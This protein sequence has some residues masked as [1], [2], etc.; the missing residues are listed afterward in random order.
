[1]L[2]AFSA[3]K[4][5]GLEHVQPPQLGQTVPD[6][7]ALE[8]SG[9]I[10][11]TPD[12]TAMLNGQ[13]GGGVAM[14]MRIIIATSRSLGA[15]RLIEIES[16]HVD[17][18]LYHGQASLDFAHKLAAQGARVRVP[19]TLNVGSVD[20]LHPATVLRRSAEEV[21]VYEGGRALMDG[22]VALGC[23][24]TWTCAPYQL[25]DR[26]AFGSHIAWAESNAVVFANSVIGA[27]TERYGDFIDICSAV[28]GLAPYAGLHTDEGRTACVVFDCTPLSS[29]TLENELT[30]PLLGYLVGSRTGIGNPVILGLPADTP[31]EHLKALGAA[32][33]SAGGVALFHAVGVTPE[34]PTLEA[35][36]DRSG[37]SAVHAI[38]LAE[39]EQARAELTTCASGPLDA[40][41]V[42]TP[43]ASI[44]EIRTLARLV[45]PA[46]RFHDR[47]EVFLSTGRLT[48]AEA[49][50]EGLVEILEMS[51]VRIVVDTCTYVTS[52]LSANVRNVMTNSAKWAH[53]AP[54]KLGVDVAIGTIEECIESA[55]R[56]EVTLHP[57]KASH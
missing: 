27:R 18:C 3:E 6:S 11:L 33:A 38:T 29:G 53:Y 19:T 55:V 35:I 52:I 56:G 34:A 1:M 20:L 41:S 57:L 30:Y 21:K 44:A 39:L 46:P 40:V 42:G 23:T 8:R 31:E 25:P 51:G 15:T 2:C 45:E 9:G 12:Q 5:R 28:T 48:L 32:A 43:H 49:E 36:L 47:V 13:E 16:G 4:Q 17:A 24:P 26:P 54:A 7:T 14:A 37:A 50:A 10:E 22:Y